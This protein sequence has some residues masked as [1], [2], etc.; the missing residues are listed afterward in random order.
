MIGVVNS[1]RVC[2]PSRPPPDM[3]SQSYADYP[4]DE[5]VSEL[6]VVDWRVPVY[7]NGELTDWVVSR[8]TSYPY[9]FDHVTAGR[10]DLLNKLFE[11]HM[12]I[13]ESKRTIQEHTRK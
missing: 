6:P 13:N 1:T 5:S 2:R 4:E 8:P 11:Q 10:E 7:M 9:N 12:F 3:M